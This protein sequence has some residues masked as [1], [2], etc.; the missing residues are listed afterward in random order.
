MTKPQK[1]KRCSSFVD[2]RRAAV[3]A[4]EALE[5][6]TF[7]S[8]SQDADGFTR[9]TPSADSRII[10][11]S[12][13]GSDNNS[14][15]TS[16]AP[17]KTFAK[18]QSL[19]RAG[20]PD[21]V[22][23]RRG[24]IFNDVFSYWKKGG[25]SSTE[26]MV[27]GSYGT[28]DR[29]EV[30][31]GYKDGITV[32]NVSNRTINNLY[33]MGINFRAS[34]RD[35][36]LGGT[37]STSSS[38]GLAVNCATH[39]LVV[40]DCAF[41]HFLVGVNFVP[42][43]GQS[44]GTV[45]RRCIITN[46]YSNGGGPA[47]GIFADGV[48]GLTL[49]QNVF[50]HDGWLDGYS[51]ARSNLYSH[52]AYITGNTSGLIARENVFSNSG[53]HGIQARSGGIIENNLF[54]NN[55]VGMSYGNVNGAGIT[56]KGG[57]SGHVSGNVFMGSRDI[58]GEGRG[59]AIE[60][61]NI[62]RDAGTRIYNNVISSYTGGQLWAI[63][64]GY[65]NGVT[66]TDGVGVNDLTIDHNVIYKWYKGFFTMYGLAKSAPGYMHLGNVT[67]QNNQWSDIT[68]TIYINSKEVDIRDGDETTRTLKLRSGAWTDPDRSVAT[69]M[70]AVGGTRSLTDF[71]NKARSRNLNDWDSRYSA[72][73]VIN[74]IRDG[75]NLAPVSTVPTMIAALRKR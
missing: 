22:L 35:P 20:Y 46:S 8:V 10:Y 57:V 66:K 75:F 18:A 34:G 50:D 47:Q 74:Y 9:V 41:D 29:P 13:K 43:Y 73:P 30:R 4:C 2:A 71:L 16:A 64:I 33:V 23:L 54:L 48:Q 63:Q 17:I 52:G 62:K 21:E 28:G 56:T 61:G 70:S 60:V 36:A 53:S 45:V 72:L 69:Y 49:E 38:D 26:P 40:E 42:V 55:P 1:A 32:G 58:N 44:Q 65:G 15:L 24:D 12:S 14:G 51:S 31:T 6:R 37:L 11:V 67:L 7:M 19:V 68:S 59:I 25:R 39:N 5:S 27:I 3:S